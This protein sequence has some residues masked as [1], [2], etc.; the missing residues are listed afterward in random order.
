MDI[1][2][3]EKDLF[4]LLVPLLWEWELFYRGKKESSCQ[5]AMAYL[6][7]ILAEPSG[8]SVIVACD[9]ERVLAF[10]TYA[11]M[12]PAP[13]RSGQ[14]YM[15]ELFVSSRARGQGV[16]KR[17]MKHLARLAWARG[18]SRF[19]W[20]AEATN[21]GAGTFYRDLGARVV[22]EKEYYRFEGDDLARFAEAP[23]HRPT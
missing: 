5:E 17:V 4:R 14:L 18:C 16:G 6:E 21:P 13:G 9:D 2:P 22:S 11:I 8:V 23:S 3:L 15:K 7:R 1:K 10:A 20:T 12:Y 19:D